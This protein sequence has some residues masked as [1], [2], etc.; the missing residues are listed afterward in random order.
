MSKEHKLDEL[1]RK[2]IN[3]VGKEQPSAA[4]K[5]NIMQALNTQSKAIRYKDLISNRMKVAVFIVL[6]GIIGLS[7]FLSND[8]LLTPI[9][10]KFSWFV[11]SLS[12]NLPNNFIYGIIVVG[13]LIIVQIPILKKRIDKS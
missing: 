12:E 4:L 7:T 1:T 9:L 8:D 5:L 6:I 10:D 2:I 13:S 11:A 3:E